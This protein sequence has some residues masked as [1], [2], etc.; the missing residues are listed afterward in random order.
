MRQINA[1]RGGVG[2]EGSGGGV[3]VAETEVRLNYPELQVLYGGK[4][5]KK[6]GARWRHAHATKAIFNM[7]FK[8][9]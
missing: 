9:S 5:K 1:N 6:R 3:G 8:K 4:K 2:W 7:D